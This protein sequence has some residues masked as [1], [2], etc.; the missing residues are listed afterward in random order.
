MS[1][2]ARRV[3]AALILIAGALFAGRWLT[4][5]LV[6]RWWAAA[7]SP[8]ATLYLTRRALVGLGLDLAA[9]AIAV[10]WLV[11]HARLT[12]RAAAAVPDRTSGGN[13]RFRALLR[14]LDAPAWTV[15]GAVILGLLIGSGASRWTDAAMLAWHG[16]G[17]GQLDPV[18]GLETGFF[19]AWLPLWLRLHLF[20]TILVLTVVGLAALAYL[21]S[22]ALRITRR[23]AITD[24]ARRHL[25]FLLALLA[26]VLGVSQ[27]L[28]PYELAA[29]LPQ[30]VAAGVA[31]L[32]RSVAFVLVGVCLA[33]AAL[34]VIW[35]LRPLHSVIAGAWLLLSAALVGA[36]YL[37]PGDPPASDD[38]E[39]T[40]GRGRMEALA[41]GPV[42][43]SA[44]LPD[45]PGFSWWDADAVGRVLDGTFP[46]ARPERGWLGSMERQAAVW[47]IATRAGDST[48]FY[49][50]AD[51]TVGVGGTPL[52][53]PLDG[54]DLLA[55]P[56]PVVALG[57]LEVRPDARPVEVGEG[58]GVRAGGLGR[59]VAMAWALQS[60]RLLGQRPDARIGWYLTPA[61]RLH[62][63]VPFAV[64]GTPRLWQDGNGRL[65]WV[66]DGYATAEA[67]P[68]VRRRLWRGRD[69]AYARAGFVGVVD[70]R[71][72][73][74]HVFLRPDA[75]PVSQAWGRVTQGLIQD[76][77]RLPAGLPGL[78]GYPA[79]LLPLQA[80]LLA[81]E[82]AR[83]TTGDST[84]YL[85]VTDSGRPFAGQGPGRWQVPVVNQPASRLEFLLEGRRTGGA[86]RLALLGPDSLAAP[87]APDLLARRWQRYPFAQQLR[88]SVLASGGTWEPGAVRYLAMPGTG[89]IAY[90]PVHG[91]TPEGLPRMVLVGVA[92][93]ERMGVGRTMDD[94][95]QNLRGV[96]MGLLRPGDDAT[97]LDEAR[98]WAREADSA[99]RRGDLAAFGRAFAALR[100]LLESDPPQP[101]P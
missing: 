27:I 44:P 54:G 69:V 42:A 84:A 1:P 31:Q 63:V 37:L 80:D 21:L 22:G 65:H 73:R 89:V 33:A 57:T 51:D 28:S 9:V 2:R 30:P 14:D 61:S 62:Q 74:V 5:F 76:A 59:R 4:T 40:A 46:A 79:E 92:V 45:L 85:P 47:I 39:A 25:G 60:G 95:L 66:V 20:A 82:R 87:E 86:D 78:L 16:V 77:A 17:F 99:L 52:W 93:G 10:A 3:A 100:T 35:A 81:T 91:L 70:A 36:H 48:R 38:P 34:S 6:D 50:V 83:R 41:F 43:E 101:D 8:A 94:A 72:G 11:L 23:P 64:W 24:Q 19:V 67:F 90:Q 13:P 56:A 26:I 32:H 71:E 53:R 7:V 98:R 15:A 68:L 88:D 58:P 96:T 75:D 29:G 97:I 18:L 12:F 49:A 55:E